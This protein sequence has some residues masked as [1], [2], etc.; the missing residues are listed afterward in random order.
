MQSQN[1]KRA[2]AWTEREVLDL[3]AVWGDESMLSELRSK[4]RNAKTFRKISE[5][6]RD[7]GYI[8][9]ATQCRMKLKGSPTTTPSLSVDTFKR[10]VSCNRDEDFGDEEDEEEEEKE[11]SAQQAS[12]ETI[13]P[14]S[15]ELFITLETIPSQGEL[16]DH[17]AREGTSGI[18]SLT[19]NSNGQ[20]RLRECGI[21]THSALLR[22]SMLAM[23]VRTHSTNLMRFMWTY[24]ID[25][26]KSISKNRLI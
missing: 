11:D 20:Q 17:E 19:Q 14:N 10:G 1:H 25:C 5:A 21:A 8:R 7:R 18:G 26:I 2:P 9:D 24:A 13:L 15:Q 3:V 22:K 6:M 12:G 4:R 16:P 23:V